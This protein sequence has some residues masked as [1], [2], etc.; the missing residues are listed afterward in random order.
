MLLVQL[1]ISALVAV[2]A[3]VAVVA[4]SDE[5]DR[6]GARF[7][8]ALFLAS[9][10]GVESRAGG[11]SWRRALGFAF[12]ALVIGLTIATVKWFIGR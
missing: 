2:V 12:G 3:T 5:F 6:L 7:T 11:S 1:G 10:V 8:A 4:L 9:L